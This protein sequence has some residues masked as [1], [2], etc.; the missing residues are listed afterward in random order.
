MTTL[1][2]ILGDQLS[3]AITSLDGI[4]PAHDII[5]MA[6]VADETT[7]V[8]HHKQKIALV[9]SAMRHFAAELAQAGF[10]VDYVTL[11]NPNN[12]GSFTGELERAIARH[13]AT[14]V[15]VTEPSEWRV[16]EMMR[17]WSS[18]LT[19][20]IEI[21]EDRRFLA[22]RAR[23]AR[24]ANGKKSLRMEFFYRELR[25]ET[26]LLMAGDAPE[27][28]VWNFDTENRK[29]LPKDFRPPK[30]LRFEPDD[31]T[32]SVIA[33]V[34][35]KFAD[36]FGDVENF[37][38]PV[39]RADALKALDHFIDFCLPSFGDYQDAMQ[40][41]APF[42]S[43]ALLSPALNIGLLDPRDM[44][45]AAERAYQRGLAPLN[46]VEG[47]IRQILGWREYI[48]GIYWFFMPDYPKS[49]ALNATR[50]LPEFFWTGQTPMRCLSETIT[51]TKRHAYAHHIQR[52]MITGNFALLAGLDPQH[53][54]A[55][56][57]AVYAD[58][59]EWVE[60]PNTHGMALYADGGVVASKPYAASGA[61]INRMSD[62]CSV[63]VFDPKA[64]DGPRACPF[65][66]LYWDFLARHSAAFKSN[67][68]MAMPLKNLAKMSDEKRADLSRRATTLLDHLD[69]LGMSDFDEQG[70]LPI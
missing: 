5:L 34:Q 70:Q 62:Y 45:V 67:P 4:D 22:T 19:C 56:Y 37:S 25:R 1:R 14:R 30:R 24:W 69:D 48:R 3:Y 12:T 58:A 44:C 29:S 18:A 47:F 28:G 17:N 21:R 23:F 11:D 46:A 68:R 39:T 7:Y 51:D 38:C 52:L 57:L 49:N 65:N 20:P 33:L 55:W 43:H 41:G 61:Y 10:R 26:G 9:L 32:R 42:L 8:K 54:E 36:H 16:Y 35:D 6:E 53:V 60:L 31:L 59:F 13:H 27:G 64:K 50:P 66:V 15:I 63:C 40:I 2:M